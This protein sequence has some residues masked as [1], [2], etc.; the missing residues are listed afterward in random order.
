MSI[1]HI[2]PSLPS[3]A[4]IALT[5]AQGLRTTYQ[6]DSMFYSH[7]ALQDNVYSQKDFEVISPATIALHES[8]PESIKTIILHVNLST[9]LNFK[10][11]AVAND[12]VYQL[13][14]TLDRHSIELITIFHEIPTSKIPAFSSIKKSHRR[15][16][17]KLADLSR[18][19]ITNNRFYERHLIENTS[20]QIYC[21][22]NFSRVGELESNNL[23]GASRCNLIIVGGIERAHIYKKKSFLQ[24]TMDTFKLN[25]IVDIGIPLPWSKINTRGLN[26][27]RMGKLLKSEI[28]DQLTI[29]KVGVLDYSR[30]PSCL[31]KSS[32]FNA[33]KA[34]GVVPLLLKDID[35]KGG[36]H[37]ASNI[38]YFTGKELDT[39]K[40]DKALA[41][42]A[43][44]N[45]SHYQTHNQAKWLKLIRGLIK[46]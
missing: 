35:S 26:I 9:Y 32:V 4:D 29:S 34:H 37:L 3:K 2:V 45:Y 24:Q 27:Q 6:I 41:K 13:G 18:S 31:G 22:N 10:C 33:Y 7:K 39:L 1:L 15:F 25:Q 43:H 16:T 17:K 12:F 36:D 19:V 20:T 23:L 30:Y 21:V 28:S 42:M 5:L 40:S 8:V 11:S 46:D 38:N 44:T 14:T